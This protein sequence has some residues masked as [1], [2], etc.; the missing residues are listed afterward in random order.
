MKL[1]LFFCCV[2]WSCWLFLFN[3]NSIVSSNV[4]LYYS[5]LFYSLQQIW[6]IFFLELIDFLSCIRMEVN[7]FSVLFIGS[8]T[9]HAFFILNLYYI[10]FIRLLTSFHS[11]LKMA[12][13]FCN[14]VILT[15]TIR[16][17]ISLYI[18]NWFNGFNHQSLCQW[19]IFFLP[20]FTSKDAPANVCVYLYIH[21]SICRRMYY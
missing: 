1:S 10:A 4:L 16:L 11:F 6:L 5:F 14:Y 21:Y 17:L 7:T 9:I 12:N 15:F 18:L 2:V 20:P 3:F 8:T 19:H 13:Y